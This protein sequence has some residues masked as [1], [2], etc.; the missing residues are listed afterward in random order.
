MIK[1]MEILG[2]IINVINFISFLLHIIPM[3]K[4][5]FISFFDKIKK[6]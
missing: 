4:T 6:K 3:I 2:F 5:K 1:I